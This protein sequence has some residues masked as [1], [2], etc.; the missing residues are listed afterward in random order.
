MSMIVLLN[1]RI[2]GKAVP[3]ALLLTIPR[4]AQSSAL[5]SR[6]VRSRNACAAFLPS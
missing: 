6:A 2:D 4:S 5:D 1:I 3:T